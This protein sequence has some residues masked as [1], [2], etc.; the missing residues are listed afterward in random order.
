[1]RVLWNLV[2]ALQAPAESRAQAPEPQERNCQGLWPVGQPVGI[3]A[4]WSKP[5]AQ[6]L[7]P[8]WSRLE[9]PFWLSARNLRTSQTPLYRPPALL[10]PGGI[11]SYVLQCRGCSA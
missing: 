9:P 8:P 10:L 2:Q 1:M 5:A 6:Y 3:L 7:R 4:A 11:H